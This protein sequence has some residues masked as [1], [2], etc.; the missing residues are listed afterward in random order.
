MAATVG[1]HVDAETAEK[2]SLGK[3]SARKTAELEKHILIC[4]SCQIAVAGSDAYV[5]AM[6]KAAA[7]IRKTEQNPKSK[8]RVAAK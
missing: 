3:L 4:E 1:P 5:A 7:K 8:R 6:R 2:Y